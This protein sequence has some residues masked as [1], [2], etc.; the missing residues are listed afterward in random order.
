MQIYVEYI[1]TCFFFPPCFYA[2]LVLE[3]QSSAYNAN[4][5]QALNAKWKRFPI[6][7]FSLGITK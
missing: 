5:K 6:L 2:S 3:N 1:L 4:L 7:A